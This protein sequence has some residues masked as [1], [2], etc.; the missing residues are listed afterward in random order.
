MSE[1]GEQKKTTHSLYTQHTRHPLIRKSTLKYNTESTYSHG[2]SGGI[3]NICGKEK[4][5]R[6]KVH[7]TVFI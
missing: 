1:A 2:G 7:Q 4:K 5:E 6:K 3:V